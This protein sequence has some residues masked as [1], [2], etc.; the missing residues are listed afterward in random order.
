MRCGAAIV[1]RG[2][3]RPSA[4]AA[5]NSATTLIA[6]VQKWR[7]RP[8][9]RIGPSDQARYNLNVRAPARLIGTLRLVQA[10]AE[11]DGAGRQ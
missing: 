3:K 7:P 2:G 1:A 6:V 10:L 9:D 11:I 8:S 5:A 4:G